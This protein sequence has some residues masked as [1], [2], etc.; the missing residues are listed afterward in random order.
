MLKYLDRDDNLVLACDPA[1]NIAAIRIIGVNVE[2]MINQCLTG[3]SR[4]CTGTKIHDP[5]R[6]LA[7]LQE[8]GDFLSGVVGR[9]L[10][11]RYVVPAWYRR[12]D[13]DVVGVVDFPRE[14][15]GRP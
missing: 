2:S 15:F 1:I 4:I 14:I 9:S 8:G 3:W 7:A 11:H 6:V 12:I 10:T 13:L 5:Y